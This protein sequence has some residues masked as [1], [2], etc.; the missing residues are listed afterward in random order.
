[1]CVLLFENNDNPFKTGLLLFLSNYSYA[2]KNFQYNTLKHTF[3]YFNLKS[4]NSKKEKKPLHF[5][6]PESI[7]YV[8]D[9]GIKTN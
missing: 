9:H 7:K 8:S 2:S 6:T 3:L 5:E 1:M 4:F